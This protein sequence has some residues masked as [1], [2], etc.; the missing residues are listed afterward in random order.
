M[1]QIDRRMIKNFDWKVL[2]LALIITL[3]GIIT[4]YSA[5][6]TEYGGDFLSVVYV[7]KQIIWFFISIGV[8]LI[9]LTFDYSLLEEYAIHIYI[10]NIILL[11]A[12]MFFGKK[13]LGAQRWLSFGGISIQPSELF[14]LTTVIIVAKFFSKED[15]LKGYSLLELTKLIV[16]ILIPVLLIVK[17]PDLGTGLLILALFVSMLLFVGINFSSI[18]KVVTGALL[19]IP[20]FWNFLKP[21]QKNRILTFIFPER[22]PLGAGY[23]IIQSKIA[24]GS[25]KLFG[26]GYLHGTQNKLNFLPEEHTDFIFS[27]FAEEWGFIGCAILILLYLIFFILLIKISNKAKDNFGALLVLGIMF[28]FF[29][30]FFINIGMVIGILPVVGIPLP[31][32]SYGGT[33]LVVS[34]AL[35]GLA[36]NVAMR[37]YLF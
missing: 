1:I 8:M 29:W 35:I 20:L 28:I 4:I 18:I 3:I 6:F 14:K 21:Y 23:H 13:S 15:K 16:M 19:F 9:F 27:V 30:Q 33:S 7:K 17:Q 31:L 22:D 24:V 34:Y 26:K 10:V 32:I 37:R 5:N 36:I 11:I 12:V 2:I 25:G